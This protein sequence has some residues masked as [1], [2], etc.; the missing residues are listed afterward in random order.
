MSLPKKAID[1]FKVIYKDKYKKE[2]NDAEDWIEN[3]KNSMVD[4]AISD[5]SFVDMPLFWV[6]NVKTLVMSVFINFG[7]QVVVKFKNI[8]FKIPFESLNVWFTQFA[9][10]ENIP[11]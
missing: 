3:V 1:E 9:F 11:C 4:Y 10:F 6:S 2:L 8:F 5:S 7:F